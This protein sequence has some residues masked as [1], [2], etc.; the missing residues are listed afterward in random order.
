MNPS[1]KFPVATTDSGRRINRVTVVTSALSSVAREVT[2]LKFTGG[3]SLNAGAA[4]ADGGCRSKGWVEA[5]MRR[6][7]L[8]S[9]T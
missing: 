8:R 4:A 5:G 3:C 2:A 7:Y 1:P 9:K 6:S